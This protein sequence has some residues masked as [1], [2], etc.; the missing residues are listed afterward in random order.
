MRPVSQEDL[1]DFIMY[2]KMAMHKEP[3]ELILQKLQALVNLGYLPVKIKALPEGTYIGLKQILMSIT[4]TIDDFYWLPGYIEVILLKMWSTITTATRML[5]YK[6]LAHGF[7]NQSTDDTKFNDYIYSIVDFG[8][9]GNSS[10]ESAKLHAMAFMTCF[11]GSDCFPVVEPSIKYYNVLPGD[12]NFIKTSVATEHSVMCAYGRSNEFDAFERMFELYPNEPVCIVA[13]TY[14]LWNVFTNYVVKLK[15]TI[16]SRQYFTAFRPDSGN[17]TLIVLGDKNAT[18]ESPEFIGCLQLLD[19]VF[20]HTL[21]TKGFK[22]LNSVKII[23]GDGITLQCYEEI[24]K[25]CVNL[26]FSVENILFGVGSIMYKNTRDTLGFAF[27]AVSVTVNGEERHICKDPITDQSK[28]SKKGYIKLVKHDDGSFKTI[29]KLMEIDE[30]ETWLPTVFENGTL[31]V[32]QSLYQIQKRI[33]SLFLHNTLDKIDSIVCLIGNDCTGKTTLCKAL[34]DK[35]LKGE[36]RVLPIERSFNYLNNLTLHEIKKLVNPSYMDDVLHLCSF[37]I[38]PH[39]NMRIEYCSKKINVN[40]IIIDAPVDVLKQR[41]N[42]RTEHDKY[43]SETA[44]KYYRNKYREMSFYYGFPIVLNDGTL[45]VTTVIDDIFTKLQNY[46]NYRE[47]SIKNIEN[48]MYNLLL[49]KNHYTK[50]HD[51]DIIDL[52]NSENNEFCTL[53]YMPYINI[54]VHIGPNCKDDRSLE[55]VLS[56]CNM[57][58]GESTIYQYIV[59]NFLISAVIVDNEELNNSSIIKKIEL[60]Y[61]ENM[62][63]NIDNNFE[64][65]SICNN[66]VLQKFASK[67]LGNIIIDQYNYEEIII[68]LHDFMTDFKFHEYDLSN[69]HINEI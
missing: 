47:L 49:D 22:V 16:M 55:L 5:Q 12:I 66:S 27:K 45:T 30:S 68:Q 37:N 54:V 11:S 28:K 3:S 10:E 69:E 53:L 17:P 56:E 9:R 39:I 51:I 32:D 15:Q 14:N 65:V 26:E 67:Y 23:Y 13:D 57:R 7:W 31:M 64:Y 2:Y 1:T 62:Y 46:S 21:N 40:Y 60:S 19:N 34:F 29:D 50:T 43:E 4:N 6:K 8:T 41:S 63:I 25:G 52:S 35:F 59:D 48:I 33:N 42:L 18:K 36:S 44:F 20:G 24:L 58:N 38:K 61:F